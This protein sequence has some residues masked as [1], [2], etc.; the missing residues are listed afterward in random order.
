MATYPSITIA[1]RS[2]VIPRRRIAINEA[3]DGS[4]RGASLHTKESYDLTIVHEFI[5]STDV[6]TLDSFY[7]TNKLNQVD[8]TWNGV[9]Y[10]CRFLCKPES[11]PAGGVT[12]TSVSRLVG[13]QSG[14]A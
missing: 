13:N 1:Q 9:T 12:W 2:T 5:T 11:Q 7:A 3:V 10:N 4:V 6:G 8:I 14:G